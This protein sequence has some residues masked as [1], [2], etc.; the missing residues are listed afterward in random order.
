MTEHKDYREDSPF[1]KE[2]LEDLDRLSFK[3]KS[4]H[5]REVSKDVFAFSI[6]AERIRGISPR[7][8]VAVMPFGR[9]PKANARRTS[10]LVEISPLHSLTS[11]NLAGAIITDQCGPTT[12]ASAISDRLT[13]A[14]A[15]LLTGYITA[16]TVR[17]AFW[18]SPQGSAKPT[19][20]PSPA[21]GK[22]PFAQNCAC[23]ERDP[24]GSISVTTGRV[25]IKHCDKK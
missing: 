13:A 2:G 25:N 21:R 22:L 5:L 3:L 18:Q 1:C 11:L 4:R 8:F 19:S 20:L 14:I 17:S 9:L 15:M 10:S 23:H 24:A 7:F 12:K 6:G 16:L